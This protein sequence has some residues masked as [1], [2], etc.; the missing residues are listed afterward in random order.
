MK[1]IT[2]TLFRERQKKQL[3]L[4]QI[5]LATKIPLNQLRNLEQEDWAS[6]SS[7]VYLQG[8]LQKYAKYLGLDPTKS[9]A[10][11]KRDIKEQQIHFIRTTD[12]HQPQSRF[13]LSR[14]IVFL[15]LLVFLFLALQLYLSWQKPLL[16]LNEISRVVTVNQPVIVKGSAGNGVLLY[17]NDELIHQDEQ[18][19]FSETLY[20]KSPGQRKLIL[21][22]IGINGKE[23][24]IE[25]LIKVKK[26]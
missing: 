9:I 1:K 23:Q 18:G 19:K 13:L 6:F 5:S 4:E 3:T 20:Y 14:T 12:Y 17:L 22:A 16:K 24:E 21:K 25:L 15:I 8:V 11:L 7:S 10:Y 2:E 26:T